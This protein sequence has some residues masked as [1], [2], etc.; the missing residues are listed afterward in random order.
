MARTSKGNGGF[1]GICVTGII[2][3]LVA[4][5]SG[6]LWSQ[7]AKS[8]ANVGVPS[9]NS[10]TE[11]LASVASMAKA[12]QF[13]DQVALNWTRQ[14]R[15]GTC[16]TNYPYLVARPVVNELNPPAMAEVRR[17]FEERVAHWDDTEKAAH[18]RWDAEVIATATALAFNDAATT[19]TLQPTTRKA[20]DRIWTL[21]NPNGAFDWLKCA[22]PP[23]EHDDY[24]GAL[25][26]ALGTGHAP[27]GYSQT[28]AAKEGVSQLRTFFAKNPPPDLHHATVLIWASTRLEGLVTARERDATIAQLLKLQR[29]DGGWCLPA[30]GGWKRRDG[31]P[32]DPQA[33]S[34][35]Y[36]T[37][38]VVF[39]LRQAGVPASNPAIER[40][41]GWL[42]SHQ[43]ASGR[44]FTRSVNTDQNHYITHAGT[45][46]AVLA[47]HACGGTDE[48]SPP[49][50]E[51]L[52]S[53]T[54]AQRQP[55]T[56]AA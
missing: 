35:G 53:H 33:P 10:A 25:V 50:A 45:A 4:A 26:A 31:S 24:Y 22:W 43:R 54:A 20:L 42:K 52:G 48:K 13:L 40:G 8:T 28:A 34:D 27:G 55:I 36:A 44:W 30:L 38:L 19:G 2:A 21:Q 9:R 18:P 56:R 49:R 5:H 51:S 14:H 32:N 7:E 11:P 15:C 12:G 47:L 37:G 3:I 6:S 41:V 23:L 46:Y 1:T 39:V 16:H 29:P 17:F